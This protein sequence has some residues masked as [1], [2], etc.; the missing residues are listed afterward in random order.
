MILNIRTNP[1]AKPSKAFCDFLTYQGIDYHRELDEEDG[2]VPSSDVQAIVT[3]SDLCDVIRQYHPA[4]T[5]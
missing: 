4:F 2:P 1:L 5:S 3:S